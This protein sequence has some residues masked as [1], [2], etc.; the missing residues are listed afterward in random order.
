MKKFTDK[1]NESVD[2]KLPTA[3]EFITN[4]PGHLTGDI[5][6]ETLM[7]EF[8]KLHVEA[9]LKEASE[10]ASLTDFAYEFLQEGAPDAIDKDTILNSY[11]LEN[12]K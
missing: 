11:S 10:K 3:C 4:H 12:I 1:I 9:A 8:A 5:D 7:I 2:D 6:D